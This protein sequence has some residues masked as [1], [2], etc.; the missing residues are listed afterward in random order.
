FALVVP[1]GSPEMD[2][3]I[4]ITAPLSRPFGP[5]PMPGEPGKRLNQSRMIWACSQLVKIVSE[6][7][8]M[9][10]SIGSLVEWLPPGPLQGDGMRLLVKVTMA[11][12]TLR[13]SFSA[14]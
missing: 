10:L 2:A 7:W 13:V 14:S 8:G 4:G 5:V 1:A 12:V 9:C 11:D 3:P 6:S